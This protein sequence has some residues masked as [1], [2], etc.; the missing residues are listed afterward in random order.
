MNSP[1]G[2]LLCSTKKGEFL[3]I[4]EKVLVKENE[5]NKGV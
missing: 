4:I 3:A 2:P 1:P 5:M